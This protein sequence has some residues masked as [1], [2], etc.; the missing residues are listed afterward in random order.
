MDELII[1]VNVQRTQS[2]HKRDNTMLKLLALENMSYCDPM[3]NKMQS[4]LNMKMQMKCNVVIGP[5]IWS[6]LFVIIEPLKCGK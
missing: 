4:S 2:L 5:V 6:L 1:F 3:Q